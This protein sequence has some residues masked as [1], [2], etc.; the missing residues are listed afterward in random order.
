MKNLICHLLAICSITTCMFASQAEDEAAAT[1]TK[2]GQDAPAFEC[3]ALDGTS[4]KLA[5]LRGRVVLISFFATSCAP[6]VVEMP[7]LEKEIW[8]KFKGEKFAMMAIGRE[9]ENK[10]LSEFQKKHQLT[11]P[12]AGDPKRAIY[13]RFA[14]QYIPRNYVVGADG[15]IAFQS[16]D[17]TEA[18]FARMI[19]VIGQEIAKVK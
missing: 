2:V 6:C 19:E 3:I 4:L 9:H 18:E 11:F 15:K 14:T 8:Q 7:H 16:V 13:S 5:N 17:Y 1:L 12:L 10:D